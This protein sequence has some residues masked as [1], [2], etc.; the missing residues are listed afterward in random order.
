MAHR[1][2]CW[3]AW[4]EGEGSVKLG[5]DEESKGGKVHWRAASGERSWAGG[6]G[7]PSARKERGG[8]FP[9]LLFF[10]FVCW[11]LFISRSFQNSLKIN[12]KIF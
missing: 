5:R 6:L 11:F 2:G 12:L 1:A 3:P 4:A 9:F 8:G 10:C 7:R